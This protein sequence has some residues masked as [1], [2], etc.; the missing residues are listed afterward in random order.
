MIR[1]RF[2]TEFGYVWIRDKYFFLTVTQALILKIAGKGQKSHL[3]AII[4]GRIRQISPSLIYRYSVV[5]EAEQRGLSSPW[6]LFNDFVVKNISQDEALSFQE[7]WKVRSISLHQASIKISLRCPQLFTWK[8]RTYIPP[9][10]LRGS[11]ICWIPIFSSV[12]PL[13]L[14]TDS[15]YGCFVVLTFALQ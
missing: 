10:I 4:K 2:R 1:R 12:I 9:W 11:F 5:P 6:Y 7:S 13:F 3:V 14:C 8:E 15:S